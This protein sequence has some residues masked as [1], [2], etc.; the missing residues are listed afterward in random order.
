[1]LVAAG[2]APAPPVDGGLLLED[3]HSV[4]GLRTGFLEAYAR[5]L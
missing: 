2:G 4:M 1:M 5:E 3:S